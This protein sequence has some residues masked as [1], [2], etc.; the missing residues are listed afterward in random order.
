[1]MSGRGWP[2]VSGGCHRGVPVPGDDGRETG[3]KWESQQGAF[4]RRVAAGVP[5]C[6]RSLRGYVPPQIPAGGAWVRVWG[7]EETGRHVSVP[8]K[9]TFTSAVRVRVAL[10]AGC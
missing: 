5:R 10:I 1:M 6:V 7:P 3:T 8:C 4:L 2:S 9:L